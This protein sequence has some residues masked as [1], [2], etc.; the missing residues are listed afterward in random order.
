MSECKALEGSRAG[1]WLVL[2]FIWGSCLSSV[3]PH[4]L[5]CPRCPGPLRARPKC[6]PLSLRMYECTVQTRQ[7]C[8]FYNH[9]QEYMALLAKGV[10]NLVGELSGVSITACR[11]PA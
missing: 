2:V 4:S 8:G 9:T 1:N 11:F 3:G 10:M 6:V 5:F 7:A